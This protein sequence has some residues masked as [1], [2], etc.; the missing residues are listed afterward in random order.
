[1]VPLQPP[2]PD[3]NIPDYGH[4]IHSHFYQ[5]LQSAYNQLI[6]SCRSDTYHYQYTYFTRTPSL[7]KDQVLKNVTTSSGQQRVMLFV[8]LLESFGPE[9]ASVYKSRLHGIRQIPLQELY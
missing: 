6:I 3:P 9:E 1:M 2:A 4:T 5:S 8:S 7:Q